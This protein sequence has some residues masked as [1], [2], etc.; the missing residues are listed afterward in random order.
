MHIQI[1]RQIHII[2]QPHAPNACI[3]KRNSNPSLES[4]A[5][6]LEFAA[7]LSKISGSN[8]SVKSV[9]ALELCFHKFFII[10]WKSLKWIWRIAEL[11]NSNLD[12]LRQHMPLLNKVPDNSNYKKTPNAICNQ[13]TCWQ[14]RSAFSSSS[15]CRWPNLTYA[16][17]VVGKAHGA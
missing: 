5:E 1:Q 9:K 10:V 17:S 14:C 12:S 13:K 15:S 4:I 16:K 8:F 6:L 7:R 11:Y 3:S 2:L